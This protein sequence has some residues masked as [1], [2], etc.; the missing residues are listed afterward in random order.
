MRLDLSAYRFTNGLVLPASFLDVDT[1]VQ[2]NLMPGSIQIQRPSHA[3]IGRPL[4]RF[5]E[6]LGTEG[7]R[8]QIDDLLTCQVIYVF[9]GR[10]YQSGVNLTLTH[11]RSLGG[12]VRRLAAR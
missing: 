12:R 8:I 4:S 2:A 5:L 3:N 7:M 6:Y 1:D 10:F 11:R 9:N